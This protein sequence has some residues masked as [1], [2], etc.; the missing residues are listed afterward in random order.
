[1]C[2]LHGGRVAHGPLELQSPS[3]RACRAG[4]SGWQTVTGWPPGRSC[5]CRD[6]DS[7]EDLSVEGQRVQKVWEPEL[8]GAWGNRPW[9][10]GPA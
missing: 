1:M 2:F 7:G 9:H 5:R 6:S 4:C 10:L 8:P 3:A